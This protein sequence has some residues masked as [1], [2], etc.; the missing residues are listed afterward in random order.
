MKGELYEY[1]NTLMSQAE[2]AKLEEINR[3]TLA[4]WYKRTGNMDDAVKGAKKSQAQRNIPYYDEVLSLKAISVKEKVKFE[5]LKKNYEALGDIYK[6]VSKTKEDQLKRNGDI[7]YNDTNMTIHAIADL[8]E[9]GNKSLAKY[10]QET[11]DIY[12]AVKLAKKAQDNHNGTILYKDEM[13][14]ITGIANLEG[15]KKDT[16]R[17]YYELY[18]NIYKAV[19]ITKESKLKRKE[20]IIRGKKAAYSELSKCFG[21]SVIKLDKLLSSGKNIEEIEKEAILKGKKAALTINEESLYKYCLDNSYNYW[22]IYYMIVTYGKTGEEAV[23][24]YL[25]NGQQVPTKWIYEKFQILFKH[26]MLNFKMDSNR[27]IKVIKEEYCSI[28]DAITKIIFV[29]N[30]QQNNFTQIEIEWMRELYSFLIDC[31]DEERKEAIDTFYITERELEFLH[32]KGKK[33]EE[34]KRQ[35]LLF[36]FASVI[37]EW[38]IKELLEMFD[39]YNINDDE[40]KIIFSELYKP[41]DENIINPSPEF[42]KHK[43]LINNLLFDFNLKDEDINNNDMISEEEKLSINLKRAKLIEILEG[44]KEENKI[45]GGKNG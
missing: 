24:A 38:N 32:E 26:L 9:V 40:I 2:I 35:I 30:N 39:L 29:S 18:D 43:D 25:D 22:V 6:A 7:P 41:F 17:K 28:E 42:L 1:N 3:K 19:F 33:I 36:E 37:D 13:M 4:D 21:I 45:M 34:I 11:G 8:E 15:I 16:L 31:D 10:Y 14:T 23:K 20:A 12:E 5:S 44:R 27:I